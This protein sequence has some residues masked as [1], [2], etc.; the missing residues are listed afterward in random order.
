MGKKT[1][2]ERISSFFKERG[3]LLLSKDYEGPEIKLDYL[4]P[5]GHKRN[6]LWHS[7]K[8]GHGCSICVAESKRAD[9]GEVKAEFSKRGYILLSREYHNGR[10]KLDYICP[11]GHSGQI[12][13]TS[14]K[15]GR[16]CRTCGNN[17]Q[18]FGT[19]QIAQEFQKRGYTLTSKYQNAYTKIDYKCP[20]GHSNQVCWG[21][22]QQGSRC[23][24]C[25]IEKQR[26]SMDYIKRI[27]EERG[28]TLLSQKYEGAHVNLDYLCP[29]K[30]CGS[31]TW[32]NFHY[33]AQDCPE[34]EKR[35][36]EKKLGEILRKIYGSVKSQDNL[37]FLG[38]LHV[39]YSVRELNLSFEYDGEHHFKP[40]RYGGIDIR[41]AKSLFKIQQE[42]DARKNRLCKENGYKIIRIRYD[43]ELNEELVRQKVS[44]TLSQEIFNG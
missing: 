23:P 1:N 31:I 19:E 35:K 41:Q 7:F 15:R 25:S 39:D 18:R 5:Q 13:W 42:R 21:D 30:H 12:N 10:H 6:I 11:C 44:N 3:C 4:C 37:G 43:E 29:N 26:L 24:D 22:F 40:T 2:I 16:G 20:V 34:C 36:G 14:F 9:W 32:S 38:R 8:R 27:F 17:S 33:L 28:Y